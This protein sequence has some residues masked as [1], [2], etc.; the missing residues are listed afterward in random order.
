MESNQ[1]VFVTGSTGLLG[2][3]LI[4][5]LLDR[6]YTVRALARSVEKA[7]RVLPGSDRLEIIEGDLDQVAA[8]LSVA[9]SSD[10]VV[11][12]AAYF[13]EYF[14]R[15][16][17]DAKLQRLNVDVPV[18]LAKACLASGVSR[19]V[20][21][22]S[23]GAISPPTDGKPVTEASPAEGQLPHNGYMQSKS[24]M[25]KELGKLGIPASK[26][27]IVRPGWMFGPHDN[28]PTGSGQIYLD[29]RKVRKYQFIDGPAF[30]IVDARDVA[31]GIVSCLEVE[32]PSPIY[33]ISGENMSPLAA[34][35]AVA[36]VH[37][38]TKV[39]PVPLAV[40]MMLSRFLEL[41]TRPLGKRNPLPL[42]GLQVLGSNFA[43]SSELAKRELDVTFRPFK[44]TARET[45]EHLDR[46]FPV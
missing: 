14:G 4:H 40:A 17:H 31:R 10:F 12:G 23:S 25:E 45:V 9:T 30:G 28:A 32:N 6:G 44:E 33:N 1:T 7:K 13:R 46:V 34:I 5:A 39:T 11:H 35:R 37:G 16:D 19:L 26:M 8:W 24:R 3:N 42:Q 2:V 22:S 43:M 27:V 36:A 29:L 38:T 41:V 18:E 21:V 20:I 15:G